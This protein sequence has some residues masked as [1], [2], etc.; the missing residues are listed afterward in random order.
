M[1]TTSYTNI[2]ARQLP[3][4]PN[5]G[6]N[7]LIL[8]RARTLLAAARDRLRSQSLP[9]EHRPDVRLPV[10]AGDA[11]ACDL[12]NARGLARYVAHGRRCYI[13]LTACKAGGGR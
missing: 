6:D 12:L 4:T 8:A 2:P 1:T 9:P 11:D 13:S 10:D 7:P 3:E 5:L